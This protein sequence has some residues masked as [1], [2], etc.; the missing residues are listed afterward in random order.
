[1]P[2]ERLLNKIK[3]ILVV[4]DDKDTLEMIRD[5]LAKEIKAKIMVTQ[6]PTQAATAAHRQFFDVILIDVTINYRGTPFGGLELY[7]SLLGRYGTS[8]LLAYSQY[9]TDDLLK[10]YPFAANFVDKH[11]NPVKF[12][13]DLLGKISALRAQQTCFVAMPFA[14]KY[15]AIYG[16][17]ENAITGFQPLR[18]DQQNF[19]KSIVER[20]FNEIR[21]AKLVVFLA[22]DK[23]PNAFYEC[24]YAVALDKEVLTITDT[25]D[26]LPFD[27]R[28]RNAIAYKGKLERLQV[29]LKK[30]LLGLTES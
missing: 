28:D 4:D 11:T 2:T 18:V 30:R 22:T 13:R 21:N 25:H 5:L 29:K 8:S 17:I 3:S 23:N 16:V 6:F 24:G 19:T 12:T 20:I 26:N 14:G 10:Q 27:I 7:G 1:M 15:D 9:I